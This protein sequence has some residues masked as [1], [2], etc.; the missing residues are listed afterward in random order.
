MEPALTE[1]IGFNQVR[2][3]IKDISVGRYYFMA[4]CRHGQE[5]KSFEEA[6]L[7][8]VKVLA[9]NEHICLIKSLRICCEHHLQETQTAIRSKLDF[10]PATEVEVA[11]A[12]LQRKKAEYE[13]I[14][15]IVDNFFK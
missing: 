13:R 9:V 11:E 6:D 3:P 8:F 4:T 2:Y 12:K 14:D 10:F 5:R 1:T 7:D 15:S